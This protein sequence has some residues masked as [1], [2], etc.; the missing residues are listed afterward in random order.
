MAYQVSINIIY[1]TF[2]TRAFYIILVHRAA[3][4]GARIHS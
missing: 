2:V 1:C 3:L 4:A